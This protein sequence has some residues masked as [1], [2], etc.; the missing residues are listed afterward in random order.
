MMR[1]TEHDS[2]RRTARHR[3]FTVEQFA[4]VGDITG[5]AQPTIEFS[6]GVSGR[7]SGTG[8]SSLWLDLCPLL[9]NLKQLP[10][11][12]W[13]ASQGD[14]WRTAEPSVIDALLHAQVSCDWLLCHL[15]GQP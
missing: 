1:V 11:Q 12:Q 4:I 13:C 9:E 6:F 5:E 14:A 2:M 10:R 3:R 7:Y 8:A 15:A